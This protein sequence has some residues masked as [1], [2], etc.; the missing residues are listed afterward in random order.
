MTLDEHY[1]SDESH[2]SRQGNLDW[3]SPVW[4]KNLVLNG[5]ALN[6]FCSKQ[7]HQTDTAPGV[8]K[9]CQLSVRCA[10]GYALRMTQLR[11]A[12]CARADCN[13]PFATSTRRTKARLLL[14]TQPAV[15]A[16]LLLIVQSPECKIVPG[17][18]PTRE[19]TRPRVWTPTGATRGTCQRLANCRIRL[20]SI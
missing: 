7:N 5:N 20:A 9:L 18:C 8:A 2:P 14:R 4:T 11:G 12:P 6:L 3:I 15:A 10:E 13:D 16:A 1:L 19:L 17:R